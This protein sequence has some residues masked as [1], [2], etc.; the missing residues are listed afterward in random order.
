MSNT[1]EEELYIELGF[2]P[3]QELVSRLGRINQRM[4]ELKASAKINHDAHEK[5]WESILNTRDKVVF[6]PWLGFTSRKRIAADAASHH[7][8]QESQAFNTIEM[9]RTQRK[10]IIRMEFETFY[11]SV[12]INNKT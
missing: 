8:R 12:R 4:E 9:L 5:I 1:L 2:K 10:N 3:S 7:C 6:I 11:R